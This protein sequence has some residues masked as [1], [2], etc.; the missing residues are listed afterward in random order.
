MGGMRWLWIVDL[1]MKVAYLVVD[2]LSNLNGGGAQKADVMR[3]AAKVMDPDSPEESVT[4]SIP[5][6]TNPH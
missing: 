5:V 6:P 3:A 1:V 2:A 4:D